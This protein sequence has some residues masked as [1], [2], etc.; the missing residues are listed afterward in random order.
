MRKLAFIALMLVASWSQ[1][2]CVL[3]IYATNS[4]VRTRELIFVSENMRHV[5]EIWER[6]W[7]LNIPDTATPYRVYGGVI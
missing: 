6:I 4:D 1:V 3:P 7:F 5:T 2:G